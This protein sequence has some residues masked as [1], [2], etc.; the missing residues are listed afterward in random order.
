MPEEPVETEKSR[1]PTDALRS[2]ADVSYLN[3]DLSY[4]QSDVSYSYT[5]IAHQSISAKDAHEKDCFLCVYSGN[6]CFLTLLEGQIIAAHERTINGKTLP[7]ITIRVEKI[8]RPHAEVQSVHYIASLALKEY[9]HNLVKEL[10]ARGPTLAQD[11]LHVR[12]YHLSDATNITEYQGMPLHHYTAQTHTAVILEPDI[13][14]NITDLAHASYCTRQ[15]LLNRLVAS[16][17]SA[18]TI[19]GNLIHFCFKELL[20]NE[21]PVRRAH[22]ALTHDE[23]S[24][25]HEPLAFLR[26]TLTKALQHYKLDLELADIT[27]DAIASDVLPHLESLAVWYTRE[28]SSLWTLLTTQTEHQTSSVRAE[29]FLLTPEIGLRGR[30]DLFWQQHDQQRFLELKTGNATRELP[31]PDHKR[32]VHGYYAQLTARRDQK[33]QK[34]QAML[35]YSGIP[36]S[37]Q[38]HGIP[39]NIRDFHRVNETRNLLALYHV[40]GTPSAPPG[41][42]RCTKCAMLV[43]CQRVSAALDWQPPQPEINLR[44]A[45]SPPNENHAEATR[46]NDEIPPTSSLTRP[47]RPLDTADDRAFFAHYYHLLQH[48]GREAD[49]QQARLWRE[50]SAEREARG[51]IIK[52]LQMPNIQQTAQGEWEQTFTCANASELRKGDEVLLSDGDPIRGEVVTGTITAISANSVTVWTPE[53][54][55]TPQQIDRYDNDLVHVRTVQNLMRWLDAEPRMRDLVAGRMRPRFRHTEADAVVPRADFNAEQLR[56][57]ERAMQMRDYLLIQGPPGTGKTSVI[58]EIVKRFVQRGQ[59]VLLAAFTNQAVDNMLKRLAQQEHFHT[60]VRIG[61]ERS[62]DENPLIQER[63]LQKLLAASPEQSGMPAGCSARAML[64]IAP[65]VASTTAT[66]SSDKYSPHMLSGIEGQLPFDVAIID[67]AS[68]LTVPALL[69]AL[70]FARSFIL[71]GDEQQL[72]PLVLHKE[73][74]G[75]QD[76]QQNKT[77]LATSLFKLLKEQDTASKEANEHESACVSLRTQYRMN[78]WIA[79]FS[80]KVFYNGNLVAG[81]ANRKAILNVAFT[82]TNELA[83]ITQAIRPVYPLV[84]LNVQ[85]QNV[86]K[87]GK[88]S[89]AEA[90]TVSATVNGLFAR[91]IRPEHIGIIAPY[92]AQVATLRHYLFEPEQLARWREDYQLDAIETRL[93]VDT[94]DRFQGGERQIIIISFATQHVPQGD[95]RDFLTNPNRL[96]VA[97]TRAQHKLILVGSVTVLEQLDIFSRLIAYCRSMKTIINA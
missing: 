17:P 76:A 36:H 60:F 78:E 16:P 18:A 41:P 79:N 23:L 52:D 64:R 88:T 86:H 27:P 47:E 57:V 97:L 61:H 70:R 90:Q 21:D 8:R 43:Q 53:R 37:A 74:T 56:A 96:N 54:I 77:G 45:I 40:T 84:F 22:N 68:Q 30:L 24:P 32:Q 29:T 71:V 10:V 7:F 50:N 55:H 72:P 62:I 82:V 93:T 38:T 14:L 63:L 73:A 34:A 95:L 59:R 12:I 49:H 67:E 80:S 83:E 92:R 28:H 39:F 11:G 91:G 3:T 4:P 19:R 75:E 42:S 85:E 25:S 15:Y 51:A 48:E 66:W 33:M 46:P 13:L 35:V 44:E 9:Y 2:H 87:S 65:V 81:A 20:K 6:T 31:K 26:K 1:P 5:D 58:A 89:H 69:G 94:V